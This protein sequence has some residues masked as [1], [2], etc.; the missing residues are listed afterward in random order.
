M[1][2]IS[3][4]LASRGLEQKE[5][6]NVWCDE[7]FDHGRTFL[8]DYDLVQRSVEAA[9]KLRGAACLNSDSLLLCLLLREQI[10]MDHYGAR[11]THKHTISCLRYLHV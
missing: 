11:S 5:V 3:N 4:Q 10:I 1:R 2:P 8:Y 7:E 9:S 6:Q